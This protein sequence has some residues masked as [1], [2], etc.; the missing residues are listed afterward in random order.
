MTDDMKK[1]N[2][3][4]LIIVVLAVF[5]A[6]AVVPGIFVGRYYIDH[7]TSGFSKEYTLY[8][9][10]DMTLDAVRDSLIHGAGALREASLDRAFE[11]LSLSERG[12]KPGK[13]LIKPSYPTVYVAR[14]LAFGW[15]EQHTLTL[16]GTMRRKG[17]IAKKISN[18]MMVDSATV[19]SAMNDE[20]FLA[21]YGFTPEDVFG[22]IIPDTYQV[23]WDAS[24]EEI[25]DR[26]KKEYDDF[27]TSERLHKADS[28]GL[29]KK[30]VSILASIVSGETRAEQEY[31]DIA[32]VYLNRYNKGMKLQADP[33]ICFCYDY[34]LDRVLKK[35]LKV[36]SPY[37]TYEHVGLPPAPIN[38]PPKACIDAV[39]NPSKH[40]YIYFCASETFDGTHRFAVTYQEHLKNARKFQK[41]LTARN[42]A[43]AA[44]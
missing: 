27:W 42:K 37:N 1:K 5:L 36:D 3:R 20:K 11:E 24:I 30:E 7:K 25:F 15:Q 17:D 9:H 6:V 23:Y 18:Q 13:Y 28:L 40:K 38:A 41:A 22:M 44:Q 32:G 16:S 2:K 8:V 12:V 31:G 10:P 4:I 33:T 21:E 19:A 34:T 14:M 35:H 43:K 26:L 29:S 39:L